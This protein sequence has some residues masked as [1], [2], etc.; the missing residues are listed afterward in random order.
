MISLSGIVNVKVPIHLHI[1][2]QICVAF[3]NMDI[4][5]G[6]NFYEENLTFKE[7]AAIGE[8][9][10]FFGMDNSNFIMNSGSYFVIIVG[11][12]VYMIVFY[13]VNKICT[14][15]AKSP[16]ARKI[17]M[18][19][20]EDSYWGGFVMAVFKLFLESY[21]DLV[22]CTSINLDA[23]TKSRDLT[24]F[25]EFFGT[26]SDIVCSLITIT[27]T[28]MCLYFPFYA[29]KYIKSQQGSFEKMDEILEV[30]MEGVN[31]YDFHSSM[32]TVYFLIRRLFTGSGLVIFVQ[33]PFF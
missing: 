25:Q 2:L 23:F 28:F 4:F 15:N 18:A 11:L 30:L 20:H 26:T 29:Y 16:V 6:E 27:Y 5:N 19:I 17:G 3:A 24:D 22:I 14:L 9:W 33:Y 13:T 1:F 12:F 31:P 8:K 21:F 10:A 7:T 32:Y